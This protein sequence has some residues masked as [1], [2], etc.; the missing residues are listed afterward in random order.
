VAHPHG[1]PAR[2]EVKGSMEEV[3]V[4]RPGERP[5]VGRH[6]GDHEQ[7]HPL[8]SFAYLRRAEAALVAD[9]APQVSARPSGAAVEQ[10]LKAVDLL[11][12][13]KHVPIRPQ[14]HPSVSPVREGF[15]P[16]ERPT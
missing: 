3:T 7:P 13:L 6:R 9:D 11:R 10:F 4:N 1:V 16:C 8:Q 15:S 12:S 5:A 14:P 2:A